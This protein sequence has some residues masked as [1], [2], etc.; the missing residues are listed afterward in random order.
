MDEALCFGWIDSLIKRIGDES[1]ARTFTPRKADSAW[2]PSNRTRYAAL[3]AGG[4]LQPSGRRRAP[5][6]RRSEPPNPPAGTQPY[7]ETAL[8]KNTR[9]WKAFETIPPWH[10]R[11]YVMWIDSAKHD[12]PKARRIK[13]AI[14][15]LTEGKPLGL[16]QRAD[17]RWKN[18]TN[19]R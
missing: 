7:I 5:T 11:R 15:M 17:E 6:N 10:R 18:C 2:S 12:E 14:R 13:Q 1:C 16:K 4:R 19:E 3:K 9:A 8:M